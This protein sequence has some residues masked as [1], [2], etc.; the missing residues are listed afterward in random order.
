MAARKLEVLEMGSIPTGSFPSSL[1]FE[2]VKPGK[3]AKTLQPDKEWIDLTS[4]T[5]PQLT[6]RPLLADSAP[7]PLALALFPLGPSLPEGLELC[8]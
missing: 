3:P 7:P 6:L 1:G 5:P 2:S 4:L 8:N